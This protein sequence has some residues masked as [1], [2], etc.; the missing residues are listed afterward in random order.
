M[1]CI[2]KNAMIV[3]MDAERRIL[4][5]G[6]VVVRGDRICAIGD[7]KEM[8]CSN[9]D[10]TDVR[11]CTNKVIFPG[12]I[13]IHTHATL[14]IIRGV[15]EDMGTAP[16]YTRSVPQ[17][18]L[19]SEYES[20]VMAALGAA[21]AL[22]FGST[23][24]ADNYTYSA[25]NA[26]VFSSLGMRA[27]V[28]ERIH[29]IEFYGLPRGIYERNEKLGDK[30]LQKNIDLIEAWDGK[31]NGR[32]HCVL[33]PH[34]PDTC[35]PEYLRC[36]ADLASQRHVGLATHLSQ[37]RSELNN[38][39]KLYHMTSARYLYENGILTSSLV[40][41]HA[42]FV[43][44]DDI[45]LIAKSGTSI[46]HAA[47]GNAKG[48]MVA[49]LMKLK[50]AGVNVGI[51]TDN[52]SADMIEVMRTALCSARVLTDSCTSPQPMEILEMATIN[53]AKALGMEN[54]IGSVEVGKKADLVIVDYSR[55]HMIPCINAV[56]NLIHTGLGS[57][58][59]TVMV[60]GN[61]LVDNGR[62]LTVDLPSLLKE[63]QAVAKRKWYEVNDTLDARLTF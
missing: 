33:G 53:G 3:T 34:A 63:A 31:D 56:G 18:D 55:P 9:P 39:N 58:V 41:A 10:I 6:A 40:A 52:G 59:D 43:T 32:I 22:R 17:G 12:F 48:G 19:L 21:E 36:V 38:I 50:A 37:S 49:P 29:D 4:H 44:E 54:E 15:A 42:I 35:T 5:D 60:D 7:T 2:F 47:E 14:S 57:D 1:D 24:I 8:L 26:E 28:S 27:V 20:S 13:N 16:A 61:I 51:A 11:D 23:L 25:K 30:L 45:A 46:A 62:M